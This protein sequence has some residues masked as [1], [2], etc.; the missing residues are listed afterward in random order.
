MDAWLV[1]LSGIHTYSWTVHQLKKNRS[2][3]IWL[4]AF[5]SVKQFVFHAFLICYQLFFQPTLKY[6]LGERQLFI[7][8]YFSVG[9]VLLH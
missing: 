5:C 6:T 1:S 8:A 2:I 4:P 7:V 9:N 3:K